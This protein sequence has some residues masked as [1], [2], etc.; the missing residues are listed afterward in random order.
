[1]DKHSKEQRSYNMSRIRSKNTEPELVLYRKLKE[2]GLKFKKH[3]SLPGKPDAV[4]LTEKLVIFVDG[5][6]WHGKGFS[7]W[8]NKLSQFWLDKINSNI[9]RDRIIRRRLRKD[10]WQ[11][12]RVWGKDIIR[13]PDKYL[14][15]IRSLISERRKKNGISLL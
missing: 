14:Q 4:F 11:I 8:K 9:K 13:E 1:M 5:E 7:K 2:A 6:Y 3:Y 10:G 15:E 12:F